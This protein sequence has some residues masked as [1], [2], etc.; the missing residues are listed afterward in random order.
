ME[1][2]W[3]DSSEASPIVDLERD[4]CGLHILTDSHTMYLYDGI[5]GENRLK[6]VRL[7]QIILDDEG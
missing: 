5:L 3:E 1:D 6:Q 2:G 7:L 4:S